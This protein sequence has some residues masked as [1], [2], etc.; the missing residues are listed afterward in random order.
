MRT[1]IRTFYRRPVGRCKRSFR[2]PRSASGNRFSCQ[3]YFRKLLFSSFNMLAIL[4]YSWRR[5]RSSINLVTYTSWVSMKPIFIFRNNRTAIIRVMLNRAQVYWGLFM[6]S[7]VLKT[8]LIVHFS[9]LLLLYQFF[10][11]RGSNRDYP[12]LLVLDDWIV[13]FVSKWWIVS[14]DYIAVI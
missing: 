7:V 11:V 1:F 12:L 3:F 10:S 13:S 2:S 6:L 8:L 5:L 9:L 14:H 4:D